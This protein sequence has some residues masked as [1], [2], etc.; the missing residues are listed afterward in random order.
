MS[1]LDYAEQEG[2][3]NMEF[4]IKS[5]EILSASCEK[6]LTFMLAAAALALTGAITAFMTPVTAT[7]DLRIWGMFLIGIAL[8]LAGLAVWFVPAAMLTDSVHPPSNQ[9]KNLYQ[10]QFT[11]EQIKEAELKN[12]E[13]RIRKARKTCEKKA[14]VLNRARLGLVW[15]F[16][17]SAIT[18][19]FSLLISYSA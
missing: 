19:F 2:Q 18:A 17:G 10:P 1:L 16:I 13:E 6:T 5:L 14:G 7:M 3:K 4:H 12:L 15:I 11:L 9:P 8:T